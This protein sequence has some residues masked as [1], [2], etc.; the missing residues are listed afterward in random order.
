[1]TKLLHQCDIQ[2]SRTGKTKLYILQFKSHSFY[3]SPFFRYYKVI[4]YKSG[5]RW[6]KL[7]RENTTSGKSLDRKGL[8]FSPCRIAMSLRFLAIYDQHRENLERAAANADNTLITYTTGRFK[9]LDGQMYGEI[10]IF[11]GLSYSNKSR[12]PY[13]RSRQQTPKSG[14][15]RVLVN[16]IGYSTLSGISPSPSLFPSDPTMTV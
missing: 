10:T 14:N 13:I 1:M 11:G 2:V 16:L 8:T 7:T 9:E 4:S 3:K 6:A 12:V 5:L 15:L